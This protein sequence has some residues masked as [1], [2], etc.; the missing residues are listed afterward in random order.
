MLAVSWTCEIRV[1]IRVMRHGLLG[2]INWADR[3][4]IL[5][6]D[7]CHVQIRLTPSH[8]DSRAHAS[9]VAHC[10]PSENALA[11]L[12]VLCGWMVAAGRTC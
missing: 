7:A 10:A 12:R 8:W 6:L 2:T 1:C 5:T 4:A 3:R 11:S 9:P